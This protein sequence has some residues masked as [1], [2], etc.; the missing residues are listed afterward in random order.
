GDAGSLID[1]L[2]GHGIDKAMISGYLAAEQAKL[3]FKKK[4][5]N[6]TFLK[7]YD[8]KI[9]KKFGAEFKRN[10]RLMKVVQAAPWL[11][12]VAAH[13]DQSKFLKSIFRRWS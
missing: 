3:A 8:Y 4:Q 6:A 9:N 12:D 2:Q 5:F 13:F 10:Y 1:P 11:I 7:Q